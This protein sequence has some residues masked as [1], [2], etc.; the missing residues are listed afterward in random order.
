MDVKRNTAH[1]LVNLLVKRG[2]GIYG[3]Q[4]MKKIAR[5][6]G[7]ELQ[8]D[9]TTKWNND[10]HNEVLHNFLMNY[11]EFNVAAKMT[12][13]VMAKRFNVPVPKNLGKQKKSRIRR[14]IGKLF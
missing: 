5:D 12:A 13:M 11:A 14:F 7:I 2:L 1:E 10:D 8:E 3:K 6:S 4:K 9:D